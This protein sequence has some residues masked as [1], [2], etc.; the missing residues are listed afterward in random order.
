MLVLLLLV[1]VLLV[2]LVSV[3]LLQM[4]V[5]L[6]DTVYCVSS[7]QAPSSILAPFLTGLSPHPWP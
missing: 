6:T 4:L 7:S 2:V 3:T 1:S 5:L